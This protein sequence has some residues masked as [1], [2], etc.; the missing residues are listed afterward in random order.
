MC[1]ICVHSQCMVFIASVWYSWPV[2]GIHGQCM[3]F[4]ASVWSLAIVVEL[5][6]ASVNLHTVFIRTEAWAFISD[7]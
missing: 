6:V 2:Y 7:K 1:C 4:I 5:M 3:V